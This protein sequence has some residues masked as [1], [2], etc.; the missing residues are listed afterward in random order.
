MGLGF[1]VLFTYLSVQYA[2]YR[3]IF[4][5]YIM[6]I[7]LNKIDTILA[8]TPILHFWPPIFFIWDPIS[9]DLAAH[10]LYFRTWLGQ[11]CI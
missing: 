10:L 4:F 9:S 8:W 2:Q 7:L 5:V 1:I 6:L 11:K 3:K